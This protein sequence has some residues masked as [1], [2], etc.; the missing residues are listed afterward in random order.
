MR[1]NIRRPH[2]IKKKFLDTLHGKI[3]FS[4]LCV[5]MTLAGAVLITGETLLSRINRV[6]LSSIGTAS[7]SPS[8][9]GGEKQD[10]SLLGNSDV[11]NLLLIGNDTRGGEKYGNSDTMLL[12]S[13]NKKTNQLKM[14]SFLRDLYVPIEGFKEKNRIN[15][16]FESGGP[17]LLIDTIQ[18]N[19]GVKIDNYACI[20]FKGFEKAIDA[21]GGVTIDLKAD[22]AKE[23]NNN[24]GVY[25]VDQRIPKLYA[26][27]Q[28][29]NGV[30]ALAYARIRHIDSDFSRT[31]RQRNVLSSLM[32]SMKNSN[33]LTLLGMANDV[34]HDINTDLTNPQ[35]DQLMLF[36]APAAMKGD[37]KQFTVPA[38]GAFKDARY[39]RDGVPMDVLDPDIP[40]NRKLVQEFLYG[41]SN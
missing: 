39:Y 5:L 16:S 41:T 26:G 40:Q 38:D 29:L 35:I 11:F 32:S 4:S 24:P 7:H 8:T 10:D 3:I 15:A 13:I 36:Q 28:K 30:E 12:L 18:K 33:P 19:F 1:N 23:I 14:V 22:E 2:S 17:S 20:D 37:L 9:S 34:F 21:V 25:V 6:P 27:T 31:Q